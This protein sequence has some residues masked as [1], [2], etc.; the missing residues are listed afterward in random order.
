MS[1][2]ISFAAAGATPEVPS[3]TTPVVPAPANDSLFSKLIEDAHKEVKPPN[4]SVTIDDVRPGYVLRFSGDLP[5]KQLEL[6]NDRARKGP[7]GTPQY[8]QIDSQVLSK[9]LIAQQCIGITKGG[10]L[11]RDDQGRTLSRS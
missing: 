9:I 11:I 6:W 1:D 5:R 10:E 8:D 7:V 2:P 4:F 3:T